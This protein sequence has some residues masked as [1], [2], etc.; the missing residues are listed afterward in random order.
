MEE[1]KMNQRQ[2]GATLA[3]RSLVI[4]A[5]GIIFLFIFEICVELLHRIFPKDNNAEDMVTLTGHV[6]VTLAVI[7]LLYAW[8]KRGTKREVAAAFKE[9]I[10]KHF[11]L[12]I[13]AGKIGLVAIYPTRLEAVEEIKRAI[14]GARTTLF[15]LGVAYKEKFF[16]DDV[17]NDLF[18][19]ISNHPEIDMRLMALN[20]ITSPAVFRAFME[21]APDTVQSYLNYY[22]TSGNTG[23]S[24]EQ[25]TLFTDCQATYKVLRHPAFIH[26][27]RFYRRDPTVWMILRVCPGS[28]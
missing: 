4:I 11:P 22:R 9:Q 16:L 27:V 7:F 12:A 14:A 25:S 8:E 17:S 18:S 26:R 24:F 19:L 2:V 20:P 1:E 13:N 28:F 3:L 6:A 21:T 15:F 10:N 5:I 23:E